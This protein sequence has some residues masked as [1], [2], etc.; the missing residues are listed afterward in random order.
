MLNFINKNYYRQI[1][2]GDIAARNVLVDH[3]G[4][5]KICDFGMSID[6]EKKK[7]QYQIQIPRVSSTYQNNFKFEMTTR[8]FGGLKNYAISKT[9]TDRTKNRPALPIR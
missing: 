1:V 5:C 9:K 4:Y 6:L 2:H 7:K 8:I 3:N